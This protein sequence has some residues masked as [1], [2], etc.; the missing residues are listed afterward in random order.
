M[1][2][3]GHRNPHGG[4]NILHDRQGDIDGSAGNEED[5]TDPQVRHAR[6][7]P[8]SLWNWG[9]WMT[10]FH[11]IWGGMD[12]KWQRALEFRGVNKA[13]RKTPKGPVYA[14]EVDTDDYL[15][16]EVAS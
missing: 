16:S 9:N 13:K 10:E 15:H 2:G 1:P 12:S 8:S 3:R 11:Y 7:G 4:R 6:N 5:Q 14:V